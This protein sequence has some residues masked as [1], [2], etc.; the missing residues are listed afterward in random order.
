MFARCKNVLI[1][2]AKAA[3]STKI[4][5][6]Q[7]GGTLL[8]TALSMSGLVGA[9]GLAVDVAQWF[10]WKRELQYAVDQAAV[11]GAY[12]LSK[13]A[14][15]KWR[16]RALSE[17]NGNRQIVT[18]N[19]SPHIRIANF[20]DNQNN[21]VIV[22][23]KASR[24]LP[25][26]QIFM[27]KAV[28]INARA[29]ATFD[30]PSL[31]SSC[32]IATNEHETGTIVLGGSSDISISCGIAALSDA[33]DAITVNGNP[34]VDAGFFVTAGTVDDWIAEN[35]DDQIHEKVDGLVDPF[36]DFVAPDNSTPRD[37][38]CTTSGKGQGKVVS[39]SLLPGTYDAIDTSCNTVLAS[40]IYVID[41]GNLKINAQHSFVGTGVMF[42]LKNGASV[43]INGGAEIALTAPTVS[44]LAQMGITDE[45]LAGMLVFED[46]GSE[47]GDSKING[48]ASTVLN[49][50]FYLSKSS[51]E[52]T[53]TA[54]V[55][56]QCLMIVADKIKLSGNG[57]LG[58][59]C[60]PG[61]AISEAD[62]VGRA[63]GRVYLVS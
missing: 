5:Q 6:N 35:T 47:G 29:Q 42:V 4:L 18:F 19:S 54:K 25:F 61:Q 39:A 9:T 59:F 50:K 40:G 63:T 51:V 2:K 43:E 46:P 32:L 48:N 55:T 56:S 27:S 57:T 33:D 13:D 36:K 15:G 60:P 52:M 34:S 16:E 26:S 49:G 30:K 14:Q 23:V 10:L 3:A 21:S 44:Q 8:L 17:F 22:E 12:S 62:S 1:R 11:S 7:R 37:Y 53:G 20:G 28:T 45:R 58:S 41:G 31:F 38:D 24:S